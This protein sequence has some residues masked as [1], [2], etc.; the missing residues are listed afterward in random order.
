MKP[1]FNREISNENRIF[2]PDLKSYFIR[3]IGDEIVDAD[4][5]LLHGIPVAD[6]DAA[7]VFTLEI[8]GDTEGSADLILTAVT[9]TNVSSVVEHHPKKFSKG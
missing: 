9:L 4:S 5:L 7:V 6:G 2:S 1:N 8:V 3:K